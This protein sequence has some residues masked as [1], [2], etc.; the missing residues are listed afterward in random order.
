[1]T[2][3]IT[4]VAGLI[5]SR[6]AEWILRTQPGVTVVGMDNLSG[7]YVENVPDGVR[8]YNLD[9][10]SAPEAVGQ[11]IRDNRVDRSK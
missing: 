5:G 11:I 7:G 2:V 3:L 4:G 10:V 8:F 6:F 9:L 1:M